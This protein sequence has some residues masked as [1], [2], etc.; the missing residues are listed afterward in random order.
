MFGLTST[1]CCKARLR[2]DSEM[3][4]LLLLL[5]LLSSGCMAVIGYI[6]TDEELAA[7]RRGEDPRAGERPAPAAVAEP[8]TPPPQ[9]AGPET[10]LVLR[11][12]EADKLIVEAQGRRQTVLIQGDNFASEAARERALN[13]RMNRHTYGAGIRLVFP[14]RDAAGATIF[15][16]SQGNLLARIE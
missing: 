3:R 13:E 10:A 16:D 9:P 12:V 1:A 4:V 5:M 11:W 6:P 7:I 8:E 14:L 2:Y 15:R